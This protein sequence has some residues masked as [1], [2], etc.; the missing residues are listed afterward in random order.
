MKIFWYV[1][2]IAKFQ[3]ARA[4]AKARIYLPDLY[5]HTGY[6]SVF[7]AKSDIFRSVARSLPIPRRYPRREA[8]SQCTSLL[9][10]P[11]YWMLTGWGRFNSY[12]GGWQ[13][14]RPVNENWIRST[15]KLVIDLHEV[16]PKLELDASNSVMTIRDDDC[17]IPKLKVGC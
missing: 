3:L 4:Y 1:P 5:P 14:S 8:S 12:N 11:Q 10:A 15:K 16:V 17:F 7:T 9:V 6:E 13:N 2:I